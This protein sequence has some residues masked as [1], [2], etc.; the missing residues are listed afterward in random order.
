MTE[1]TDN[2]HG[3][4]TK[5]D[6][7]AF[8]G[9]LNR[10]LDEYGVPPKGKG[11]Q[12]AVAKLFQV[13]QKGARKWLE[14]EGMPDTKK[15]PG[16][17]EELGVRLEWLLRGEEPMRARGKQQDTGYKNVDEGPVIH[18]RVPLISWVQAGTFC[19]HFDNYEPGDADEW[20]SVT[21][22]TGPNAFALEVKGDSMYDPATGKG[23]P[24]G[25]IIV[26]DPAVDPFDVP[27][28]KRFVVAR[29]NGTDETTF[30]QLVQDGAQLYLKPIN[31]RYPILTVTEDMVICGVVR[32]MHLQVS[33]V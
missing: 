7:Q 20:V 19:Q 15:L 12:G 32:Q 33:F 25:A 1:S 5:H 4:V 29:M 14:A 27:Q 8:S 10:A 26:V 16:I 23:F 2:M 17:C 22:R 3:M 30:K 28:P 11:R 13:S 6:L 31:P 24:E 21:V 18:G 9:R